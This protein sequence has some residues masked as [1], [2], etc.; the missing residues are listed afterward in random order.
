M[1]A[2]TSTNTPSA[3]GAWTWDAGKNDYV[4]A[5]D[6]PDEVKEILEEAG[7]PKGVSPEEF[8]QIFDHEAFSRRL[9]Q[10][11]RWGSNVYD[12]KS[13]DVGEDDGKYQAAMEV[14]Y[15]RL[16]DGPGKH[17]L[18]FF[19]NR[20]LVDF[21]IISA[22]ALP[23]GKAV[24]DEIKEKKKAKILAQKKQAQ[25]VSQVSDGQPT[26]D[27]L[28]AEFPDVDGSAFNG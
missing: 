22:W 5:D 15:R 19:S 16:V 7:E 12:L 20:D 14:A 26:G 23:F 28:Q 8:E 21:F 24:F 11:L 10:A 1:E 4:R 6:L 3:L 13:L 9:A 27:E 2:D 25:K 17:L 18:K